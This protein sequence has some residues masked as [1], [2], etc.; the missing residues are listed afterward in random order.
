MP[1]HLQEEAFVCAGG[2]VGRQVG[3]DEQ[4]LGVIRQFD[5]S[6]S[7]QTWRQTH[8]KRMT[9]GASWVQSDIMAP[10][11]PSVGT[12]QRSTLLLRLLHL[13]PL[14]T[15]ERSEAVNT[16]NTHTHTEGGAL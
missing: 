8:D 3:G 6:V 11:Q 15:E 9:F 7:R 5:V 1:L 14:Q 10:D 2:V 13:L 4:E 16:M 12:S